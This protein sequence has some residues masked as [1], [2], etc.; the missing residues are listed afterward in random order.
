MFEKRRYVICRLAVAG[1]RRAGTV[2]KR[3][4]LTERL[5]ASLPLGSK[6]AVARHGP[7]SALIVEHMR[8]A[9]HAPHGK[10]RWP[11]GGTRR[12]VAGRAAARHG[13]RASRRLS[14]S[15]RCR[16]DSAGRQRR[17]LDAAHGARRARAADSPGAP[18]R[19]AAALAAFS[20]AHRRRVSRALYRR[21]AQHSTSASPSKCVWRYG[22]RRQYGWGAGDI[23]NGRRGSGLARTPA[24]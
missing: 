21:C 11:G 2:A 9:G 13:G 7:S 19:E 4:T 20:V 12:N 24:A 6:G 1:T 3:S 18:A 22:T 10:R 8:R 5:L 23:G 15:G 14:V 17:S 16:C